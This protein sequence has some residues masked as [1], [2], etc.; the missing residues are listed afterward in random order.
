MQ[1]AIYIVLGSIVAIVAVDVIARFDGR[2]PPPEPR[3]QATISTQK[4]IVDFTHRDEP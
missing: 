4:I 1:L 3:D 2:R